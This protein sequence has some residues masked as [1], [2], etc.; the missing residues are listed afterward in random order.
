M[1]YLVHG[2]CK[3]DVWG[4]YGVCMGCMGDVWG[5]YGV[6]MDDPNFLFPR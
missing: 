4:V 3:E 6:C 5:V 1:I 2:K